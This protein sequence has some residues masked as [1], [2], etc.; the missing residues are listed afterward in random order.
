MLTVL[1]LF[2]I[3]ANI[4]III[5]TRD[6]IY[7]IESVPA[8]RVGLVLGTSNKLVSGGQ[9]PYFTNRIKTAAEL[10]ENGK[11]E[12]LILSGDNE[13]VYYNEPANMKNE[14][15]KVGVPDSSL[16][17]D[18]AGFRT[19]D[20]IV[21]C[22]EVFGQNDITIV[23]QKFH[24]YRALYICDFYDMNAVVVQAEG[25]SPKGS[26]KVQIREIF[27]RPKALLDLYIFKKS[28]K[29]LGEKETI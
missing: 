5:S 15:L 7:S 12:H 27:A 25:A 3:F 18:Y 24:A 16:T 13:T 17:L 29:F 6:H 19:L 14:I 20:S 11:V 10:I 21:R 2:V 23:T 8:N 28:P 26:L 1:A 22:K 9:N 4:I